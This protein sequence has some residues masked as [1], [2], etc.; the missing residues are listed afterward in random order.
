[1]KNIEKYKIIITTTNSPEDIESI[2]KNVLLKQISPC[3]QVINNIESSY[4][5][6]NK[7]VSDNEAMIF[8]KTTA[9]N[10]SL[11]IS[12]IIKNHSYDTPEIISYDFDILSEKYKKWFDIN[13]KNK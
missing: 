1:M 7:I 13:I 9:K 2:K 6:K 8:I 12:E 11:V 4:I 5:W 10:E 3:V